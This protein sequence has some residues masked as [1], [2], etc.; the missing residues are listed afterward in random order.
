VVIIIKMSAP[1]NPREMRGRAIL[2]NSENIKQ[3]KK[4][5]WYVLREKLEILLNPV[6]PIFPPTHNEVGGTT[7]RS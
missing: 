2:V 6:H 3:I 5:I 7:P 4:H 1:E